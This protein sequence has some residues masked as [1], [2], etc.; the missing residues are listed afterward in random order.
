MDGTDKSYTNGLYRQALFVLLLIGFPSC[1]LKLLDS[2]CVD[3]GSSMLVISGSNLRTTVA[4]L[5]T[6]LPL[7]FL[8]DAL[9]GCLVCIRTLC[10][11]RHH[12]KLTFSPNANSIKKGSVYIVV[13]FTVLL[14][15]WHEKHEILSF[16]GSIQITTLDY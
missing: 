12:D 16:R 4:I 6:S 7:Q 1:S 9:T 3:K 2:G 8:V 15:E 13:G 10:T 5:A 14:V 11:R